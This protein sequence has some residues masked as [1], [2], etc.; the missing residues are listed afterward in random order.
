[1]YLL[2]DSRRGDDD[3]FAE[4]EQPWRTGPEVIPLP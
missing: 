2:P 3:S 4:T 1:M